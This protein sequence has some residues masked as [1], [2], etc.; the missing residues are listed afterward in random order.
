MTKLKQILLSLLPGIFLI[1]YNI[2]TGS[3]TAMSKAGANFGFD[4]LWAVLISCIITYYLISH[5]SRYTMVSGKTFIQGMRDHIHPGLAL[6]LLLPLS[7]II[8]SALIGILGIISEVLQV[9]WDT[10]FQL[11]TPVVLWAIIIGTGTYAL[12]WIGNYAFFEKVLAVLVAV[13]GAAFIATA[14]I[15]F[16]RLHELAAGLVPSLPST[17]EGSDNSPLVIVAGMVGT[18]V[19]VFVFI[20]R[21]Q[22]VQEIGWKMS[23]NRIQKRDALVSASMMF[24]IGASILITA[25]TTLHLQGLKLNNVVEMIPLLEPIAGRATLSVFAVGI[26]AA[27]LSSHLPNML[28]IPW[29]IID[30]R[31]EAR[32]TRTLRYRMVLLALSVFSVLGVGLGIKPVF[33]MMLSQA[34]LSIV[35]PVTIASIFYLTSRKTL[36]GPAANRLTDL[37]L[38]T[39]IMIFSLYMSWVGIRGL[40]ADLLP[41]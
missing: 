36:M 1:G 6:F 14:V 4:L 25:A 5:F 7:L 38:L 22:I 12:L 16:P 34:S 9:W 33:I 20:I 24:L 26:L 3:V 8:I 40:M 41:V 17:A 30:Y 23:D 37:V 2:G 28:V 31:R 10:V 35:L 32:E 27:G 15:N 29:L 18:T 21:T 11:H 13:M 39:L 19:S